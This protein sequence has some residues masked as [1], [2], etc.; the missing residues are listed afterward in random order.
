MNWHIDWGTV[1]SVVVALGAAATGQIIAHHF[2]QSREDIKFK[3]E[4]FQNLYSPVIVKI[5]NYLFAEHQKSIALKTKSEEEYNLEYKDDYFNPNR[6]FTEIVDT[7]G[8]NLKYAN[9]E[10][11]MRYQ[12]TIALPHIDDSLADWPEPKI[13]FC[14]IFLTEYVQLS[15]DLGV[16]SPKIKETVEG[17][18]AFTQLFKL[19]LI[20]G[21]DSN[22]LIRQQLII[23]NLSKYLNKIVKLNKKFK[24]KELTREATVKL[25]TEVDTLLQQIQDSLPEYVSPQ[26]FSNLKS[27]TNNQWQSL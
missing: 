10:L 15:K 3:K 27:P 11:I 2:S 26:I 8:S 6:L 9:Q 7:V 25:R 16:Y 12:D 4:C 18:L 17:C 19:F 1:T 23:G 14:D 13:E 21:Y 22:E 24:K 20:V 5:D